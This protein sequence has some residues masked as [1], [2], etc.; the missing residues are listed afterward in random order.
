VS[1]KW[2]Y[3]FGA[4]EAARTAPTNFLAEVESKAWASDQLGETRLTI[5]V[6]E[7]AHTMTLLPD[8]P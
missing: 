6:P 1:W 7:P 2:E 3:A 4:E 8:M 5:L